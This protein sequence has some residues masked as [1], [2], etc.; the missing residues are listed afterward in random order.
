VAVGLEEASDSRGFLC[1]D[2]SFGK[3][4]AEVLDEAVEMAVIEAI[5]ARQ[6]V[7]GG[8]V[9][10]GIRISSTQKHGN[11]HSLACEELSHVRRFEKGTKGI[12]G[13]NLF[14]EGLNGTMKCAFTTENVIEIVGHR[15][16]LNRNSGMQG[17]LKGEARVG[18]IVA[19]LRGMSMRRKCGRFLAVPN[20]EKG[21]DGGGGMAGVVIVGKG[22]DLEKFDVGDRRAEEIGPALEITGAIDDDFVPGLGL[23]LDAFAIAEP[24]DVSELGGEEIEFCRNFPGTG[25]PGLVN[26]SKGDAMFAEQIGEARIK[27]G[28][29][30][31][32]K[33]ELIPTGK[34]FEEGFQYSEKFKCGFEFGFV[35]IAKLEE[36]RTEFFAESVHGFEKVA[37]IVFTIHEDFF[38][39]DDL[40]NFGGEE[41]T[42]WSLGGPAFDGGE[43]GSAVK[44]VIELDGVEFSGVVRKIV[45]GLE[46]GRIER[47]FPAGSGEG[48]G[49]D[50]EF[51]HRSEIL[52]R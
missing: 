38:M 33:G 37:E 22:K 30:T 51:W 31:N 23:L 2:T 21:I 16:L 52:Q 15:F 46:A 1:G 40:G 11:K 39:G 34:L 7:S 48:A 44:G 29:I 25:H 49:A 12:V 5:S 17:D 4:F 43:C 35:E 20:V 50:A 13:E 18:L 32:F 36:K 41:K 6:S 42:R 45:G 3:G 24:A 9:P 27:P 14:V 8:D 19:A 47:A 10:A 26:E 28:F